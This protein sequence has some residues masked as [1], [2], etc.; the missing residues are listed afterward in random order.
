MKKN[1]SILFL[2]ILFFFSAVLISCHKE[3]LDVENEY[4]ET[5]DKAL[6]NDLL[7]KLPDWL[8]KYKTQINTNSTNNINLLKQN[9]DVNSTTI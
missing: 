9:L 5:K 6:I 1:Y 4:L 2:I 7:Q 8:D 3:N